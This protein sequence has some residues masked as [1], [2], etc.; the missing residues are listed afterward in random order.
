PLG[1]SFD[2]DK[3]SVPQLRVGETVPL[4][5]PLTMY[6]AAKVYC[7]SA[8][9]VSGVLDSS[10]HLFWVFSMDGEEEDDSDDEKSESDED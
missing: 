2:S 9:G 4:A 10:G 8:R 5:R 7:C 6:N 3:G 1:S